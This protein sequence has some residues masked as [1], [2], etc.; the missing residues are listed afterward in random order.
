MTPELSPNVNQNN[1]EIELLVKNRIRHIARRKY[2]V[3]RLLPQ[4]RRITA[5]QKF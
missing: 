4:L 1:E 3:N 2:I 5:K